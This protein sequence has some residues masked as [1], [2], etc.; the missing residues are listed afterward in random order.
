M[1]DTHTGKLEKNRLN[2]RLLPFAA[3]GIIAFYLTST[4]DLNY[5]WRGYLTLII[6]QGGILLVYFLRSQLAKPK[7]S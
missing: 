3:V 4:S 7:K 2:W 6:A 5:F 1:A